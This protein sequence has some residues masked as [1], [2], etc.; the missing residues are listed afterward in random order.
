MS[1]GGLVR[2]VVAG[3]GVGEVK[4]GEVIRSWLGRKRWREMGKVCLVTGR[5]RLRVMNWLYMG[6]SLVTAL[7]GTVYLHVRCF[8]FS[9]GWERC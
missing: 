8:A 6:I 2:G 1:E 4:G 3:E 7:R 5:V 9:Y